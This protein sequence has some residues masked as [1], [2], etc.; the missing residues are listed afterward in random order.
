MT[1]HPSQVLEQAANL[2]G[3]V[4]LLAGLIVGAAMFVLQSI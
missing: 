1:L 3:L 2:T 4:T